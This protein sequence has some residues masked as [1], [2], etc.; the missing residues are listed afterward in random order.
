MRTAAQK[1]GLRR[2]EWLFPAITQF[3]WK[4]RF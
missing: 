3:R 2:N 4:I 1:T